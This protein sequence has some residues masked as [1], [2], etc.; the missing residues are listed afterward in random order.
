MWWKLMQ[1][2]SLRW[3]DFRFVV[4]MIRTYVN[5]IDNIKSAKEGIA[6]IMICGLGFPKTY[7]NKYIGGINTSGKVIHQ[8]CIYSDEP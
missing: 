5:P 4:C 7:S 1:Q 3:Q 6:E 2:S 8:I